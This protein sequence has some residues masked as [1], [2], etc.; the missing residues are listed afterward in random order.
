MY[1]F[2]ERIR[3]AAPTPWQA[4]VLSR[5]LRCCE[6]LGCDV[7]REFHAARSVRELL[8]SVVRAISRV[9][10]AVRV[11]AALF[12]RGTDEVAAV[13]CHN[14]LVPDRRPG[15]GHITIEAAT[16]PPPAATDAATL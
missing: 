8:Q 15:D 7:A 10:P 14:I 4:E 6:V 1:E 12:R 2:A 11:F 3:R 5:E 16:D 9:T 13:A